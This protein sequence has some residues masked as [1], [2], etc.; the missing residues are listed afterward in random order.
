[1]RKLTDGFDSEREHVLIVADIEGSSGC[2]SYRASSFLTPEWYRACLDMSRDIGAVTEALF[3]AGVKSVTIKDFHRTGYNL[4]RDC[5]DPR[6]KI[7]Y[8]YRKGPVPG[9]GDAGSGGLVMFIGMHAA[10]GSCGFLAHTLTSRIARLE[11]NGE[12]MPEVLL[13]SASLAPAGVRPVFFS[14]CP[15]ACMQAQHAIPHIGYLSIMKTPRDEGSYDRAGWRKR[16]AQAAVNSLDNRST[17][18]PA[19]VGPFHVAITMR[20]GEKESKR[21]ARRWKLSHN[22]DTITFDAWSFDEMYYTLIRICYLTRFTELA[23]GPA[24]ALYNIVGRAGLARAR[25][26]CRA[27]D[28]CRREAAHRR[29]SIYRSR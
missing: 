12:I 11:V 22:A 4:M 29:P 14:G 6:A 20:D 7:L 27:A 17:V 18:I 24:L 9:I 3:Q 28:S 1:M 5:I 25:Q 19:P 16:L 13:F 21:L 8:G 23:I 26:A 2:W 15:V 10:S